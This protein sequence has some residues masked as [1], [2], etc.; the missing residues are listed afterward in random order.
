MSV[1]NP[2]V[3]YS[4]D[5][6]RSLV[7]STDKRYEL[8]DGEIVMFLHQQPATSAYRVTSDSC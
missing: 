8:L 7:A 1:P 4:Y 3:Q 6:Y 2:H 5:D